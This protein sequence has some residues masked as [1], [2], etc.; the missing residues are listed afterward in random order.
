MRPRPRRGPCCWIVTA[1]LI[2]VPV[3][4]FGDTILLTFSAVP[5]GVPIIGD[6]TDIGIL[7]YGTVSAF[8]PLA[9]GVNRTVGG[10][11]YTISTQFGVRVVRVLGTTAT[12]TLQARLQTA[13]PITWRVDGV[14][15]TTTPA[16]VSTA[17]PYGSILAHTLA[18]VVPFS[19]PSG[20][21][22]ATF[23]VT[24]VAN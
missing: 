18:F 13:Q 7:N 23:E 4:V 3:H 16:V 21:V 15:I 17:Q 8:E 14:T 10:S 6:G 19:Q 2:A 20:A 24:A 11:D 5:G 9:A 22:N 12:Y 1:V